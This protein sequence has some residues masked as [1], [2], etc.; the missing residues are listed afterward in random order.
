MPWKNRPAPHFRH[1]VSVLALSAAMVATLLE[2][3][4]ALFLRYFAVVWSG[5][6]VS[7]RHLTLPQTASPPLPHPRN[8]ATL[9]TC[10]VMVVYCFSL[11]LFATTAAKATSTTSDILAP[12]MRRLTGNSGRWAAPANS[13]YPQQKSQ[14]RSV[15][16]T[17]STLIRKTQARR[18]ISGV[19]QPLGST[20]WMQILGLAICIPRL[21]PQQDDVY[22]ILLIH[23]REKMAVSFYF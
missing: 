5:L 10:A 8:R 23:F 4:T 21:L 11:S 3:A 19:R 15:A 18:N 17:S 9:I 1:C 14:P 7:E 16:V 20:I 12:S 2:A 6:A 13:Y 22:F